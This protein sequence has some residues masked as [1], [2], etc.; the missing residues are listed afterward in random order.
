M[1][2]NARQLVERV[3]AIIDGNA[4][5]VGQIGAQSISVVLVAGNRRTARVFHVLELV[6][7]VV[8]VT[9][10]ARW[11]GHRRAVAVRVVGIIDDLIAEWTRRGDARDFIERIIAIGRDAM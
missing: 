2:D 3:I 5:D 4:V 10:R 1:L 6:R 8:V 11:G 7:A 9:R